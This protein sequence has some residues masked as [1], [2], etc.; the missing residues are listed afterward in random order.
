MATVADLPET[1]FIH[2]WNGV[3]KISDVIAVSIL[4]ENIGFVVDMF[5]P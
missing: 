1:W 5:L 3:L 2:L 4:W